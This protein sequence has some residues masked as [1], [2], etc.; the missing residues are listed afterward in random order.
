MT[1]VIGINISDR[2]YL[3]GDTQ[4]SNS[5][6][7]EPLGHCIKLGSFSNKDY[8]ALISCAYAGDKR[9]IRFLVGKLSKACE[10]GILSV[11][12]YEFKKQITDFIKDILPEAEKLK[13]KRKAKIIFAGEGLEKGA[14]KA[15]NLGETIG[16]ILGGDGFR[17]S[18]PRIMEAME[19]GAINCPPQHMFEFVIDDQGSSSQFG[20]TEKDGDNCTVLSAGSVKLSQEEKNEILKYFLFHGDLEKEPEIIINFI[21][22]KFQE[23]IGGAVTIGIIGSKSKA[24]GHLVHYG[25]EGKWSIIHKDKEIYAKDPQ[26]N[27][28]NLFEGFYSDEEIE[29]GALL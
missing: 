6:T 25:Y 22:S 10:D 13:L 7:K 8:T 18:D 21:R 24:Y 29:S 12:I 16:R 20:I 5:L 9:F 11:D 1:L 2:I 27:E 14:M 17:V 15:W 4:I 26:G 3:A 19:F 28:F 23:T